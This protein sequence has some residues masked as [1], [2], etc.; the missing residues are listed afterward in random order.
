MEIFERE[1]PS[2]SLEIIP[3]KYRAFNESLPGGGV[4]RKQI[5]E[6]FGK[7]GTGKTSV[8]ASLVKGAVERGLKVVLFSTTN[9]FD[10]YGLLDEEFASFVTCMACSDVFEFNGALEVVLDNLRHGMEYALIVVDSLI[11]IFANIVTVS[12]GENKKFEGIAF[13]SSISHKL[14]IIAN[15]YNIAVVVNFLVFFQL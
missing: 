15:R 6:I 2:F 4:A 12:I 11:S 14:Q 1:E 9:A 13:L 10:S 7:S 3:S 5:T 8:C